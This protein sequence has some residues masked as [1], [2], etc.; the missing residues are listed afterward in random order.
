[1]INQFDYL[2]PSGA[3]SVL[4]LDPFTDAHG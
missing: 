4:Q 1:M 2:Q 3:M